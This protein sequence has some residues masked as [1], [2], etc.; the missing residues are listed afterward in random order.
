MV[1]F[2]VQPGLSGG[3]ADEVR[4]MNATA[5]RQSTDGESSGQTTETLFGTAETVAVS[6]SAFCRLADAT[7][8]QVLGES[9]R[10][11]ATVQDAVAG[12]S[13]GDEEMAS[14]GE[15]S[16]TQVATFEAAGRSIA[17][18]GFDPTKFRRS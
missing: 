5:R 4:G 16:A 12:I 11:T 2:D 10:R 7:A 6:F 15:T 18:V 9:D 3:I 14:T 17:G 1:R 8:E 13:T